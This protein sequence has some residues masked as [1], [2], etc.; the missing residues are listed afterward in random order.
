M[1]GLAQITM[2]WVFRMHWITAIALLAGCLACGGKVPATRYYALDLPTPS[3]S[4]AR[5]EHTAILM[6]I[7]VGQVIGQGRIVY[8]ESP[9]ELGFYD[10]HRWAEDPEDSVASALVHEMLARGTFATVVPFNGRTRADF[11]L[12]GEL[13]RLEEIDYDG[14]VRAIFEISLELVDS[15]TEM[16]AWSSTVSITEDVPMSDVRS[17]V[18]RMSAAARQGIQ[19]LCEQLDR[20]LRSGG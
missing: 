19:Q 14:P 11:V 17:V 9:E 20:H 12:R 15:G 18:S 16:V 3:P 1:T 7:R 10:Y 2:S 6:P 13:R 5:L 4:E 8:R